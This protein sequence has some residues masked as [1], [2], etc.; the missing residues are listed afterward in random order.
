MKALAVGGL[1]T[2]GV[3]VGWSWWRRSELASLV[4]GEGEPVGAAGV[5]I[6]A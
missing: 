2:G 3:G 6:D 4:V 5:A 1:N